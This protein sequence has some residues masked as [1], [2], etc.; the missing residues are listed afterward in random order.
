LQNRLCDRGTVFGACLSAH[1]D[2]VAACTPSRSAAVN[3][4]GIAT[5]SSATL[6]GGGRYVDLTQLFCTKDSCP[7]IVGNTLVY[8]D[9]NHLTVE[10]S[11][12]LAPAMG[13]LADRALADS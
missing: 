10:H 1:L 12:Q 5:E 6:A 4:R 8:F 3:E 2:D 9:D 13:A 7:V 11:R